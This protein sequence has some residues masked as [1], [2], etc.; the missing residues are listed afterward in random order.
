MS[1]VITAERLSKAYRIGVA[2]EIPDSFVGALGQLIRSPWRNFK[3]LRDLNTF[4]N[5]SLVYDDGIEAESSIYWALKNVSFDV[6]QGEVL[7]VIGKNGAGKSTLLKVLSR[8][9]EPTSGR[10]TI[11]GRVSSL[12]EVGTGFHPELS[13]R[14][15]VYLNGTILGMSKGEI[16]G[17]F[18]QI[19]EFSGIAKFLDTPIKRYS[20]GMKVR[21]AFAVAAHL[22]PEV[23][24]IDEV[25]AVGDLEFQKRCIGKMQEIAGVGRTVIFVSHDFPSVQSLCTKAL[26][27]NQGKASEKMSPDEAIREFSKSFSGQSAGA[28][29]LA[30][31][32]ID[33]DNPHF[34][35]LKMLQNDEDASGPFF[36]GDRLKIRVEFESPY[37]FTPVIE[38]AVTTTTGAR[39]FAVSNQWCGSENESGQVG[40]GG[41]ECDFGSL[42]LM[43]GSYILQVALLNEYRAFH[44]VR[45]AFRLEIEPSD[46][47]GTGRLPR[48]E[49]GSFIYR[50]TF[51]HY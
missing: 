12:L 2:E 6:E 15:N 30:N 9:T 5:K 38:V 32:V 24:I 35:K 26:I 4:G 39:L 43:P 31:L 40:H 29:D 13:G 48:P 1:T 25:L 19:V 42:P 28:V 46:F 23:L 51:R 49:H 16:D 45:E 41:I 50:S 33:R 17:K 14:E 20:S 47:L 3:N 34:T 36:V 7:G 37:P 11:R 27:M 8:I 10:A 21:L 44:V 18:D 22:E